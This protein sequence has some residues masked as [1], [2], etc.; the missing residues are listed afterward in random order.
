MVIKF[1]RLNHVAINMPRG[2]VQR[3]REFYRDKLNLKEVSPPKLEKPDVF[4][5]IWFEMGNFLVHFR[6]VLPPLSEKKP[7]SMIM[8]D[9]DKAHFAIEVENIQEVR[10]EMKARGVYI[11][12]TIPLEDRDRFMIKK[13]TLVLHTI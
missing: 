13:N 3:V 4:D 1:V 10:K 12:E 11:F 7:E 5:F 8:K 2:E 9:E 6:F